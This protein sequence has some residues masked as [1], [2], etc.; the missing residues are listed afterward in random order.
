MIEVHDVVAALRRENRRDMHNLNNFDSKSRQMEARG[1]TVSL[2]GLAASLC[3]G[4]T[5]RRWLQG[6]TFETLNGQGMLS[7]TL[8]SLGLLRTYL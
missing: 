5:V 4:L 7:L 1:S 8:L 6:A 3:D 2:A